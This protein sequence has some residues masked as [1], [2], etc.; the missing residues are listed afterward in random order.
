MRTDAASAKFKKRMAAKS[1]AHSF[2]QAAANVG[3]TLIL[4]KNT[5]LLAQKFAF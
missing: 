4:W 1:A 3:S 2:V 5:V